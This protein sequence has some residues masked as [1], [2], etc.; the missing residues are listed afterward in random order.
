MLLPM[1][2][3]EFIEWLEDQLKQLGMNRADLAR[4]SGLSATHI[5]RILNGEQTPG[6][7]G[8]LAIAKGI[9][10]PPEEVFRRVAGLSRPEQDPVGDE[11]V[12][13]ISLLPN[14]RKRQVLD[15]LRYLVQLELKESQSR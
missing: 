2:K 15:Y 8:I 5:T 6:V 3:F 4:A 14:S 9:T 11:A 7:D 13:L 10:K 12:Y 1:D